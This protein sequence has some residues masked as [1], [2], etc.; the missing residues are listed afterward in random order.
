MDKEIR[1]DNLAIPDTSKLIEFLVEVR[2]A[3]FNR[4]PPQLPEIPEE[5]S[6]TLPEAQEGDAQGRKQGS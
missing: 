2:N 1:S 3:Y 5:S 4:Q 6:T